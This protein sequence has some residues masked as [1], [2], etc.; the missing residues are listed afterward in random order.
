VQLGH[1]P[2]ILRPVPEGP[3]DFVLLDVNRV[4]TVSILYCGC[5]STPRHLQL[6]RAR[7]WPAT[8]IC[9]ESGTTFR[10]LD[11]YNRLNVQGRLT[12]HNFWE[13]LTDGSGIR[14]VPDRLELLQLMAREY[15]HIQLGKRSGRAHHQNGLEYVPNGALVVRCPVFPCLHINM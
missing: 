8:P 15:S 14:A 5:C 4:H 1:L 13:Q 10:L 9:P 12:A 6:F 7:W 11:L 2:G 3:F